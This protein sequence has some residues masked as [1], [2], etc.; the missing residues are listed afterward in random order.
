MKGLL[1]AAR[2]ARVNRYIDVGLLVFL[3]VF[4]ALTSK[5]RV[6]LMAGFMAYI[7]FALSLDLLWGYTGLMSFG[8]AVMFGM[9]A[10]VGGLTNVFQK[11]VPDFMAKYGATEIPAFFAPLTSPALGNALAVILPGLLALI[12]GIFIFSSRVSGVFFCLI[13]MALASAFATFTNSTQQYLGGSNGINR[14]TRFAFG[15]APVSVTGNYYIILAALVF[16]YLFCLWL[17]N[18][19]FGKALASIAGNEDRLR[20]LGYKT[21]DF[22]LLIF[23]LS[24]MLA[25]FAGLLSVRTT[26]FVSPT[27]CGLEMSTMVVVWVAVGG[28]GN[29]TGAA[30]G[31]L[32]I[33][34]AESILSEHIASQWQLTI[35][36]ILLLFVLFMRDGLIGAALGA[37][38]RRRQKK[39]REAL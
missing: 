29:L 4:P 16:A 3:A 8:H 21:R 37:Q 6:D 17:V 34:W 31:T 36:V 32:L 26:G 11:G 20:F 14:I 2:R 15:D 1:A 35:G 18:T 38:E 33:N 13:T 22:K 12:I 30:A 27:N 10:Y 28:R 9:G 7:I 5:F 25:G 23:V 19:R 24:G 39:L